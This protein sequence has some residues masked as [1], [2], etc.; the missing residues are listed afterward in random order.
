M[1]VQMI[2]I[3]Y[4]KVFT[5]SYPVFSTISKATEIDCIEEAW[6]CA[7]ADGFTK[8]EEK[9]EYTFVSQ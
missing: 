1:K 9:N 3:Q 8:D 2:K 5:V 6:R 7:V 4:D